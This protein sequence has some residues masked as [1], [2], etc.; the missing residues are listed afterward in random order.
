VLPARLVFW[1]RRRSRRRLRADPAAARARYTATADALRRVDPGKA[2]AGGGGVYGASACA[3]CL[4][5]FAPASPGGSADALDE[6]TPLLGAP[7]PAD[8]DLRALTCG[9]VFHRDCIV[10]WLASAGTAVRRRCPICRA[11][12]P[13]AAAGS[14]V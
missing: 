13:A 9:H 2:G 14:V 4:E 7:A 6:A 1:R 12:E 10:L 11:E 3:I 5:R 8:A